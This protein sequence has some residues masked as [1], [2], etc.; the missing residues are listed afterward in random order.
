MNLN[1]F[2][3]SY[4]CYPNSKLAT[5]INGFCSGMQRVFIF[6]A[7]GITL[8]A[9]FDDVSNR[10]EALIGAVVMFVLWLLLKLNKNKWSDKIA[11]KQEAIDN[12]KEKK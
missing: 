6:F 10:G 2:V 12:I 11:A 4:K 5:S 7:I 9:V 1:P 3:F 8:V